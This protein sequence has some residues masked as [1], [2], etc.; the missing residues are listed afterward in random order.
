MFDD[1]Q[2]QHLGVAEAM[3]SEAFGETKALAQP[4]RMARTPSKITS[5]PPRRGE[6]ADELLRELG[7]AEDEISDL[8]TRSV[9]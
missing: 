5:P 8:R 9:V 3:E 1:P 2:V 6:H 7:L 4:I